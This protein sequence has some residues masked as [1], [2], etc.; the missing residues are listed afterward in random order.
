MANP[1]PIAVIGLGY[2]GLPF[3]ALAGYDCL[4][5][6]GGMVADVKGIWRA[7]G[8]SSCMTRWEL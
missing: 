2:V 4:V 5:K 3:A 6:P 1:S 8:L 7:A